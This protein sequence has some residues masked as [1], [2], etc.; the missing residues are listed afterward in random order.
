MKIMSK[1]S[2][3]RVDAHL[4]MAKIHLVGCLRKM[5]GKYGTQDVVRNIRWAI[6]DIEQAMSDDPKFD[7]LN[8]F[9]NPPN[10][11]KSRRLGWHE[12]KGE[13]K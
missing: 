6:K 8:G 5:K 13:T 4:E 10:T 9:R 11:P 7:L 2:V 3:R 1:R 12:E